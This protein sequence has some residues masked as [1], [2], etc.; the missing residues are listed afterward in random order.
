MNT[1][2]FIMNI[3]INLS[4]LYLE[5]KQKFTNDKNFDKHISSNFLFAIL[6]I[7][8]IYHYLKY[9]LL[10]YNGIKTVNYSESFWKKE[11][12]IERLMKKKVLFIVEN[13]IN[14]KVL[15]YIIIGNHFFEN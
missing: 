3:L 10:H 6:N 5:I 11:K 14:I 4:N 8:E 9:E 7:T 15:I 2:R 13:L 12:N 1:N